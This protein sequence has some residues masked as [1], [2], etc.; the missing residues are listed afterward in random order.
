MLL[1]GADQFELDDDLDV[2]GRDQ[3][4]LIQARFQRYLPCAVVDRKGLRSDAF[5]DAATIRGIEWL[6]GTRSDWTSEVPP[7][8][9]RSAATAA[10][11]YGVSPA[12]PP[13]QPSD[14]TP[15]DEPS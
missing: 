2:I 15:E 10:A 4:N 3:R 11:K 12:P 13:T 14:D 1:V 7:W 9:A 8:I 5:V 6:D